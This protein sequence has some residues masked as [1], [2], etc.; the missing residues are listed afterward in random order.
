MSLTPVQA[1]AQADQLIAEIEHELIPRLVEVARR[2]LDVAEGFAANRDPEVVDSFEFEP[3]ESD[4]DS[5]IYR[6]LIAL[7]TVGELLD[8][9]PRA[10]FEDRYSEVR[11]RLQRWGVHAPT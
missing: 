11:E 8:T 1:Q 4:A 5:R 6:S 2:G 7:Q 9:A 3:D 10:V